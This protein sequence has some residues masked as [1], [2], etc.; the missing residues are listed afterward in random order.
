MDSSKAYIHDAIILNKELQ[1]HLQ[2][3][4]TDLAKLI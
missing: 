1:W 4:W 3:A 2:T